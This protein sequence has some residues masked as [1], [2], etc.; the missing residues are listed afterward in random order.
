MISQY[1]LLEVQLNHEQQYE[2]S[3]QFIYMLLK[4]HQFYVRKGR[5]FTLLAEYYEHLT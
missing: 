1:L 2:L 4:Q 3:T 5:S